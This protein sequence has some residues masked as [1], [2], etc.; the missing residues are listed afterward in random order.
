[1]VRGRKTR[2]KDIEKLHDLIDSASLPKQKTITIYNTAQLEELRKRLS[3]DSFTEH[4]PIEIPPNRSTV[5]KELQPQVVVHKQGKPQKNID[6]KVIQIDLGPRPI[7]KEKEHPIVN[8]SPVKED[9]FATQPLFEIEKTTI[10]SKKVKGKTKAVEKKPKDQQE[11]IPVSPPENKEEELL[12]E[13]QPVSKEPT[14]IDSHPNTKKTLQK[15]ASQMGDPLTEEKKGYLSFPHTRQNDVPSFEPV[16]FQPTAPVLEKK[17]PMRFEIPQNVPVN[18]KQKK[19]EEKKAKQEAKEKEKQ[20]EIETK[21]SEQKQRLEQKQKE[22]ELKQAFIRADE[23]EREEQRLQKEQEKKSRLEIIERQKKEKEDK[24]QK[25][26]DEKKA[27]LEIKEK[28]QEARRLAKEHDRKLKLEWIEFQH[29]QHQ[30]QKRKDF[31]QKKAAVEL[32]EKEQEEQRLLKERE[33]KLRLDQ[34]AIVKKEKEG[35]RQKKIEEKKT[36][37]EAKIKQR[38]A[39]RLAKEREKQF[40]RETWETKQKQLEEQKQKEIEKKLAAA[41]VEEK[42]REEQHLLKE[43]EEKSHLELLE[44]Q[45]KEK[46]RQKSSKIKKEKKSSTAPKSDTQKED[47][48]RLRV[49]SIGEVKPEKTQKKIFG[50]KKEE[51]AKSTI[52]ESYDEIPEKERD[53]HPSIM[54]EEISERETLKQMVQDKKHEQKHL[55]KE[56]KEKAR[57]ERLEAKKKEKEQKIQKKIEEKQRSNFFGSNIGTKQRWEQNTSNEKLSRKEMKVKESEAK[58]LLKEEQKRKDQNF[59]LKEIELREKE[60]E[61]QKQKQ[62]SEKQDREHISRLSFGKAKTKGVIDE[63]KQAEQQKQTMDLVRIAAEEK[64]LRKTKAFERKMQKEQKKREKEEQKYKAK[65]EEKAKKNMDIHMKEEILKEK[66]T[67]QITERS[68]PFVAFD[69]ID[70]EIAGILNSSGIATIEQLRQATVKDLM[71]S[72][73]KK[74]IAQRIIAECAEFVEWQVFDSIDHF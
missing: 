38:E 11:F 25:K 29:K 23:E 24:K 60:K 58:R 30:N 63:R 46:E 57:Q 9:P 36:R 32:K 74:K 19:I 4:K 5:P 48:R 15:K 67:N 18:R 43:M 6:K 50:A 59:A 71:K 37:T 45:K 69:S 22:L 34:V 2:V 31:E 51:Q 66:M 1:M 10:Q 20:L 62:I 35:R 61:D 14:V 65:E 73:I 68:D 70:P 26:I 16:D 12:P 56:R 17:E 3:E 55:A 27:R 49:P 40:K 64:E 8:Y 41:Q 44:R 13:F 72:G 39:K 54:T 53:S 7:Q 21:E 33:E 47:N 52:W 42:Q 28:K